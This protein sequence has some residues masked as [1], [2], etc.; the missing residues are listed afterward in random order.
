VTNA[1][2]AGL[3]GIAIEAG[4]SLV[5]E[6]EQLVAAADRLGLFV[7]GIAPGRGGEP[8]AALKLAVVAGEPS[9]DILGAI[10][11]AQIAAQSGAQP[12]LVGVGGEQLIAEGLASLF[13]LHRTVHHRFSEVIARLPR[14]VRRIS[15]TADAIIAARPDCLV[16]IDSPDFSHRV[17]R[18]VH[19][20]LPGSQDHQ[21]CLPHRLGLEA[22]A[23]GGHAAYVDHV[24]SIFPFEPEIVE[25]LG[26]PPLTYVGHRL[27]DDPG[28][29]AAREAQARA[30]Q[31]QHRQPVLRSA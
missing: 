10:W 15:Q 21:L 29:A 6:R 20:A 31:T 22:R 28:L 19:K 2:A 27:M 9:G 3:A 4:R 30:A 18:K 8:M 16:I 23:G 17:A 13:D 11:C 24:L 25:R 5:L 14:L 1:H 12:E 26:G 7:T